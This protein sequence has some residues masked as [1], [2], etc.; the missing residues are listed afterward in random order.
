[1]MDSEAG[2]GAGAEA[3]ARVGA[4]S[5]YDLGPPRS[6]NPAAK[7]KIQAAQEPAAPDTRVWTASAGYATVE[8]GSPSLAAKQ[9]PLPARK[10]V[11]APA[12]SWS[13]TWAALDDSGSSADG[14]SSDGSDAEHDA[15]VAFDGTTQ[16]GTP[17]RALDIDSCC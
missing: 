10:P 2:A 1:M 14:G 3:E 13:S 9:A 11:M 8:G 16:L 7:T 4:M 12:R 15:G 5:E 6:W 17:F